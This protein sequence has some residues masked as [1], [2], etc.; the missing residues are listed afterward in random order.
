MIALREGNGVG[1]GLA[2]VML[3]TSEPGRRTPA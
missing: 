2:V 1:V 3:R